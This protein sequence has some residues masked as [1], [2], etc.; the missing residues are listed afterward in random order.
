MNV[1]PFINTEETG[2]LHS[3]TDDEIPAWWTEKLDLWREEGDREQLVQQELQNDPLPFVP[4]HPL[5]R[6]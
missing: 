2:R 5:I 6:H 4:P 1:W 3:R